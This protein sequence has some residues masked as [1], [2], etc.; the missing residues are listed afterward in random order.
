MAAQAFCQQGGALQVGFGQDDHHF[1]AAIAPDHI[2]IADLAA[3]AVGQFDQ[4]L[5]AGRV[6]IGVVDA[7]EVIQVHHDG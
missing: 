4:N 2:Y 3:Q 1:L 6:A 7:F 5:V